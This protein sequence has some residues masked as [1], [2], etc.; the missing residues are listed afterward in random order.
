MMVMTAGYEDRDTTPQSLEQVKSSTPGIALIQHN[1]SY[2]NYFSLMIS[3]S[4]IKT[5]KIQIR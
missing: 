2:K 1:T 3:S 4:Q 5:L